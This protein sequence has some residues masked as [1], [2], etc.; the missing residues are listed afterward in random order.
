MTCGSCGGTVRDT[1][2]F[3]P[4]CGASISADA[5]SEKAE[6]APA[7]TEITAEKI[8]EKAETAAAETEKAAENKSELGL[9]FD[10]GKQLFVPDPSA[11]KVKIPEKEKPSETK[12]E[13]TVRFSSK[14]GK[15]LLIAAIA[16][17]V[18]IGAVFLIPTY[19]APF[20]KYSKAERLFRDGEYEAAA[21]IFTE[22]GDYRESAGNILKCRYGMA[23]ILAE[24]ENFDEAAEAFAALS[25]FSDSD[26]KAAECL[27]RSADTL[28]AKGELDAA[29]SAYRSA[30]RDDLAENAARSQAERLAETGDL[31]SAAEIAEKY[32]H[33]AALEYIY[34][35]SLTAKDGGDLETAAAGFLKLGDYKDSRELFGECMYQTCEEEFRSGNFSSETVRGFYEMGNYMD[36]ETLFTESAYENGVKLLESGKYYEASLMFRNSGTYKDSYAQLHNALYQLG[37]SLRDTDSASAYSIFAMLGNY[38]DSAA[39]KKASANGLKWYADGYTS[40]DGFCTSEFSAEDKLNVICTVGTDSP[41]GSVTLV[42]SLT[43]SGGNVLSAECG[44]V[45]NSSSFSA[46]I[47]LNG[48][49]AGN[50]EIVISIK[51]SGE[52]LR[53]FEITVNAAS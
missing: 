40:A 18:C 14:R 51:D 21:D 23:E 16:A 2:K 5:K 24:K 41:S 52:V 35:G 19:A 49:A 38:S 28:L 17:A 45:R 7:E 6:T 15:A 20:L 29:M 27:I 10:S 1:A 9:K 8:S 44:N 26:E 30:G 11:G 39:M 36:S 33:E 46:E 22:L 47:P 25:G 42:I 50:A 43:D 34:T 13:R 48:V 12:A 4:W 3:C 37:M 32:S 31:F 53:K